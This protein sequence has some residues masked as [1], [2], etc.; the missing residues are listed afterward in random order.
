MRHTPIA[1]G[2]PRPGGRA[3]WLLKGG[4]ETQEG[5]EPPIRADEV[6]SLEGKHVSWGRSLVHL[7]PQEEG[8]RGRDPP[9]QGTRG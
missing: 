9:T 7:R 8:P 5:R 6:L 1:V 2:G 3:G 4:L